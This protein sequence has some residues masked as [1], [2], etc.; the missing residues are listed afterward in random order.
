MR[1][2]ALRLIAERG[3]EATSTD[4]IARAAGVSPRTFFNYFPTKDAVVFLPEAML[5][6]LVAA[7][8]RARPPGEDP[9]AALAAAVLQTFVQM[10]ELIGPDA[11]TFMRVHLRL[12]LAEPEVRRI[13]FERRMKVEDAAWQALQERGVAADDLAARAA[14]ATVVALAFLGLMTWATSDDD[15]PLVAALTRCLLA[16]P[17]P[18]RLAA[19]VTAPPAGR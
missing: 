7:G 17:H 5:P 9:A 13:T 6:A 3:Y 4:D 18:S 1:E 19:G 11:A 10:N 12:V 16:A 2:A 14:V 8:L 15:E